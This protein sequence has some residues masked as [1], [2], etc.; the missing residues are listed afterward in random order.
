MNF[1]STH[2][3]SRAINLFSTYDF[4]QYEE[5][6]WEPASG[7]RNWQKNFVLS[8]EDYERGKAIYK[9]YVYSLAF[10]PGNLSIFYGDEMGV[11]GM[12][13]LSNRK[14]FPKTV[15][16]RE[17]LEYFREIGRI[18]NKEQFLEKADFDIY[19]INGD[20]FMFRRINGNEDALITVSRTGDTKKTPV[21]SEYQNPDVTY[22]LNKSTVKDIS[23]YGGLVL[24]KIR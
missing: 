15:K 7:D 23:P 22:S 2:D 20:M 6:A 19:D 9:S 24:K 8:R 10:L 12:G 13:N 21:P 17:L 11:E 16:D 3:I 5:W 14:P 4:K 1:T 18:R